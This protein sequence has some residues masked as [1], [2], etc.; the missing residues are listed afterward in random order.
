MNGFGKSVGLPQIDEL[1]VIESP[2]ALTGTLNVGIVADGLVEHALLTNPEI[3]VTT[4]DTFLELMTPDEVSGDVPL[5]TIEIE[6]AVD[7]DVDTVEGVRFTRC[8]L[9][10]GPNYQ[11]GG[12]GANMDQVSQ[13]IN[14]LD[15]KPTYYTPSHS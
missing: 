11:T 4:F 14:S 6:F 8:F 1:G 2:I 15:S 9:P 10:D 3:G 5:F 7:N 12:A 13:T